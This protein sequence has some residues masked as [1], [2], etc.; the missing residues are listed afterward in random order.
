VEHAI[1]RSEAASRE[2]AA[3]EEHYRELYLR[4]R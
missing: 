4:R 3:T 1:R 2:T